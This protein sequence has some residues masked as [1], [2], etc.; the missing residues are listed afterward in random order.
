[1]DRPRL[2][3]A[4][5]WLWWTIPLVVGLAM[6]RTHL[7]FGFVGDAKFLIADNRFLVGLD[8]LWPNLTHDYFWSS[9][10]NA[11]PYY[12]PLTK[13]SWVLEATLSGVRP[14]LFHAVQIAWFSVLL[15]GIL[16]LARELGLQ[17]RFALLAASVV[18]I[19]P[20]TVEPV[21]LIMAR[22]DVTVV[23]CST[24]AVALHRAY[25]RTGR[26]RLLWAHAGCFVLALASK[27]TA[28]AIVPVIAAWT[29]VDGKRAWR[30]LLPMVVAA[31]V[32]LVVR[33]WAIG[34]IATTA[35]AF[36]PLRIFVGGGMSMVALAQLGPTT[37]LRSLSRVEAASFAALAASAAAWSLAAL[38]AWVGRRERRKTTPILVLW[39]VASLAL[40]LLPK[41]MWVPNIEGKIPLADRWILPA[42]VPTA[43]LLGRLTQ[44]FLPRRWAPLV[45]LVGVAW[46]AM[47]LAFAPG[48]RADYRSDDTMLALEERLYQEIPERFRTLEDRC[49]AVDREVASA[50][51]R[52]NPSL[53]LAADARRPA[54]CPR[55]ALALLNRLSALVTLERWSEASAAADALFA[56]PGLEPRARGM[57]ALLGGIAAL[58]TE[59][60]E[61]A[62]RL[63]LE[64]RAFGEQGCQLSFQAARAAMALG[65]PL[66][67]ARRFEATWECTAAHGKGNRG[68]LEQAALSYERAGLPA[69]AVRARAR[70]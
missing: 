50:I 19:H 23:A 49:H 57:A 14:W 36:D 31:A 35:L 24:W 37:G 62:E 66:D 28:L 26:P 58:E 2:R 30:S 9:A 55:S 21:A 61:R 27:E 20:A 8:K 3:A 44:R 60:P 6:S 45:G 56:H 32:Y 67:A 69:E 22:S 40:V 65:H 11:I 29:Y 13:G 17:R 10:G 54:P 16:R 43:L 18:A 12:R 38:A 46:I 64:A 51:S 48:V 4:L 47:S 70:R 15:G 39:V 25:L 53:A 41:A 59:A 52:Q 5:S 1:M 42:L 34:A 7:G 68:M 63:F 33:R